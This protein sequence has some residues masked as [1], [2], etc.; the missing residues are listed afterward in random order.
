MTIEEKAF[1]Q[2]QSAFLYLKHIRKESKRTPDAD[3]Y[4]ESSDTLIALGN[5]VRYNIQKWKRCTYKLKGRKTAWLYI[6]YIYTHVA[7]RGAAAALFFSYSK[8]YKNKDATEDKETSLRKDYMR[9]LLHGFFNR[10]ACL[11]IICSKRNI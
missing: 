8:E 6:K 4:S 11:I 5:T 7:H 1:G 3:L 9:R 10:V 2:Q